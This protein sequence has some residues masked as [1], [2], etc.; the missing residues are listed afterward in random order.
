MAMPISNS[1]PMARQIE[2]YRQGQLSSLCGLYALIN[3]ARLI[4]HEQ[5]SDQTLWSD[6]YAHAIDRIGSKRHLRHALL[7]GLP[8]ESWKMLQ[9]P[10]CDELSRRLGQP[11]RM[12]V[13]VR[14]KWR[15]RINSADRIRAAID[16]ER[17]VLCALCGTHEHYTVITG[18]TPTR[19]YLHDSAGLRWIRQSVTPEARATGYPMAR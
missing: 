10:I 17:A 11:L 4:C 15:T 3:A 1:L 5:A 13:L 14:R 18:Y 12:R 9:H 7:H 6:I 2:P 16:T 19:W 8:Y